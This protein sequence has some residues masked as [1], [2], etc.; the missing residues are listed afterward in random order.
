[1]NTPLIF[2]DYD[3]VVTSMHE[4]PGSFLNHNVDTYGTSPK[5]A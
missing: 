2:L 3:G 1:M 5:C 4:T